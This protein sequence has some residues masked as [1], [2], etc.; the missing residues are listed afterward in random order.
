[1]RENM[2]NLHSPKDELELSFIKSILDGEGIPYFVFNDHF[3]SLEIGPSISMVNEKIIMVHEEN[4]E[5]ARELISEFFKNAGPEALGA[6]SEYSLI[7]KIRLV[8]ECLLFGWI[9]PGRKWR[10]EKTE[11]E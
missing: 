2:I 3:G 9:M 10:K 1:M 7:D 4:L 5:S 8:L 6:S 11:E